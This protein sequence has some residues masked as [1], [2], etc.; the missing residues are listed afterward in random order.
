MRPLHRPVHDKFVF[1]EKWDS[2]SE[3]EKK[4]AIEA[5]KIRVPKTREEFIKMSKSDLEELR[6]KIR[7]IFDEIK[8]SFLSLLKQM[9]K[10]L[11]LVCRYL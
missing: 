8:N 4:E 3:K 6:K 10:S 2:M 9:P 7:P 1:S 11:L 5:G